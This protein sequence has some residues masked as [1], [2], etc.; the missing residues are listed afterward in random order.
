MH[1]SAIAT[2]QRIENLTVQNSGFDLFLEIFCVLVGQLAG[3]IAEVN[4]DVARL[5]MP[6]PQRSIKDPVL[7][8]AQVENLIVSNAVKVFEC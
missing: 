5:F 7:A 8:L 3:A 2:G 6:R 1:H 4:G